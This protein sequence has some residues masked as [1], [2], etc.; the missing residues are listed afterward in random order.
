MAGYNGSTVSGSISSMEAFGFDDWSSLPGSGNSTLPLWEL[1]AR[2][3]ALDGTTTTASPST[4]VH[5][6]ALVLVLAP[7]VQHIRRDLKWAFLLHTYG[8]ACLFFVLAFYAF[9]SIL[10]LRSLISARPFMSSING[11]LCLLGASRAGCLFIDPYNL[12]ETMPR[13]I[14]SVLWDVGFPCVTSAF[15]LIQ[16]AFFQ[17]TQLKIGPERIRRKSCLSLVIT[18]HFSCLIG[19]DIVVGFH[20]HLQVARYCLQAVFLVWP[21]ALSAVALYG[22]FRVLSLLKSVPGV[23]LHADSRHK[24]PLELAPRAP[25]SAASAALCSPRTGSHQRQG[26][27]QLALL[28]PY[29]NLAAALAPT[30]LAPPKIH[31][32]DEHDRTVSPQPADSLLGPA[33]PPPAVTVRPPTPTMPPPTHPPTPTGNALLVNVEHVGDLYF[34][35]PWRDKPSQTV[36]AGGGRRRSSAQMRAGPQQGQ[37]QGRPTSPALGGC[38]RANTAPPHSPRPTRQRD[39][40]SRRSLASASALHGKCP[41]PLTGRYAG[42]PSQLEA[43][44]AAPAHGLEAPASTATRRPSSEGV[45]LG[46]ILAHIAYR[47]PAAGGG[48]AGLRAAGCAGGGESLLAAAGGGG[49]GSPVRGVVRATAA[50]AALL[51]LLTLGEAGR[52]LGPYGAA[53]PRVHQQQHQQLERLE[54][55]ERLEAPRA[56]PWFCFQTACRALEFAVGCAMAAITRQPARRE[57]LPPR[58]YYS[59]RL[60]SLYI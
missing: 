31:V 39:A 52:A 11:F 60:E 6:H 41:L 43:A 5:R 9:F 47:A 59:L 12:K 26:I 48:L 14:G 37:S 27:M 4:T 32:T 15:C 18:A 57:P 49:G 45:T 17:L 58:A 55:L 28:A 13:V 44:G 19:A 16:L 29:G 1:V 20:D 53:A 38:S 54:R 8:F 7:T 51:L 56:W 30:L 35:L 33:S 21:L 25:A 24:G 10:N 36:S 2:S 3:P 46:S 40:R 42:R 34:L 23:G 22:A 50:T